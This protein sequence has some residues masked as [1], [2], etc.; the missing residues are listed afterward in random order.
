MIEKFGADLGI[1][2]LVLEDILNVHQRDKIEQYQNYIF[3]VFSEIFKR[4]S[5]HRKLYEYGYV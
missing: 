2:A 5:H 3:G 4:R 1:D